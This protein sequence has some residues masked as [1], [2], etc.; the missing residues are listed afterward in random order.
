M[1]T[2]NAATNYL[3]RSLLNFLF[4]NNPNSFATPGNSIYVG[5]ATAVTQ[6]TGS[7]SDTTGET[8][9]VTITEI[10]GSQDSAYGRQQVTAANW[11]VEEYD[12]GTDD[13][14]HRAKN[15]S[16][17][18]FPAHGSGGSTYTVTHVFIT[19]ASSA[20]LDASFNSGNGNVLFVGKLD[21]DKSIAVGDI[22]RINANNLTVELR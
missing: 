21:V 10:T 18:E 14:A 11:T 22:F 20:S 13:K 3:E 5:L 17:I 15:S 1:A 9:E 4:K 7:Y 2:T 16:N 19:T 6:S 12:A 8:N